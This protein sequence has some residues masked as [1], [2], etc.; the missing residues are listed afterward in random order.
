MDVG[1]AVS[2]V[3]AFL[4]VDTDRYPI[5]VGTAH[6]NEAMLTLTRE[7]D[8]PYVHRSSNVSFVQPSRGSYPFPGDPPLLRSDLSSTEE[9]ILFKYPGS[10]AVADVFGDSDFYFDYVLS[11]WT[12]PFKSENRLAPATLE[13]LYD[14][15]GDDEG[16]EP[17]RFAIYADRLII[18]P[19]PAVGDEFT[20]RFLW[21]GRP[22]DAG[23]SDNPTL[24]YHVPWGVVYRACEVASGWLLEDNRIPLFTKA[25]QEQMD[26]AG[27]TMSMS[28]DAAGTAMKEPG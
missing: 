10:M 28:E 26:G 9:P 11:A 25:R 2:T 1:K 27:V 15:Y 6:V 5:A 17:E 13:E 8:L 4:D 24:L 7:Y 3:A 22:V 18:R 23:I 19:I 16:T 14:E 20:L 12:S 21:A